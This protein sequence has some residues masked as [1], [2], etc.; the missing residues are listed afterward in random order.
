MTP[1]R[2]FEERITKM[3]KEA[4]YWALRIPPNEAGQQPFDIIAIKGKRILTYD[5]KLL[6]NRTRFPLS[7]IED[8]QYNA[9]ELVEK[10]TGADEIGLLILDEDDNIRFMSI[11]KIHT[12]T[13]LGHKSV[14]ISD[15]PL[16][17]II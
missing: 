10:K 3:L 9:F 12:E 14:N 6:S 1:D 13:W 15:L 5:A 16:W 11:D 4:G 2:A 8:N 7:R 17:R